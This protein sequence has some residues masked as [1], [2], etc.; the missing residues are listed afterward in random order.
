VSQLFNL[1]VFSC[2]TY[3]KTIETDR[4]SNYKISLRS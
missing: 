1:L 2:I 3:P 4:G